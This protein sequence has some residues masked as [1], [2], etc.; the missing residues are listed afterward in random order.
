MFFRRSPPPCRPIRRATVRDWW[1]AG[2]ALL[3]RAACFL[4]P[5]SLPSVAPESSPGAPSCVLGLGLCSPGR[6]LSARG[7]TSGA[8]GG[9]PRRGAFLALSGV[10]VFGGVL[11]V[12]C[13]LF[14][15]V[16][17]VLCS[18]SPCRRGLLRLSCVRSSS[19]AAPVVPASA[20]CRWLLFF[21][22]F[23]VA[24]VVR[25]LAA[26]LA[27]S[28]AARFCRSLG[29]LGRVDLLLRGVSFASGAASA[30]W[31]VA[32]LV[33]LGALSF[34]RCRPCRSW[35]GRRFFLRALLLG[36]LPPHHLPPSSPEGKKRREAFRLSL[37][38]DGG[39]SESVRRAFIR[40]PHYSAV[41]S[42]SPPRSERRK[43]RPRR[44]APCRQGALTVG[45]V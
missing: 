38:R 22:P 30:P 20:C 8:F 29:C 39:C 7:L 15:A 42:P 13:S 31:F 28:V 11:L 2:A 26:W 6:P 4:R 9:V 36:R 24:A 25:L 37:R 17:A 44:R 41:S 19:V 16:V 32:L 21:L 12:P 34:F 18:L 43:N 45:A 35:L 5:P 1:R 27:L 3:R 40:S 14:F 23:P 33:P 10:L